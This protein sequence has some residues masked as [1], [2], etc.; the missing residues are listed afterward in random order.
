ML[1]LIAAC[2]GLAA[3]KLAKPIKAE[4]W[5]S[6][7]HEDITKKALK[8]LEKDGKVK[9]AQF[10]KPYHEEI[11]KGC[12]E[13]DQED[14]I[15]RGPGMHFYSSRTPK[16]KE[17]KPV[18]GYYKNRL[19]KFAKSARTLLEENYTSALCLYKSGKTKEA[20][21]YLARAA[22]FIED[23]SCTVHVCNV[24]WVERASNLHHAYENSIN[25]TCSRFTAGEFDKRLLKTYEGDSFE[26]AANKLSVTAA[27]FL[28]KISE[29]DPLAF[30]FA[31][32]NTLKMAQQNVMTLFLKF[33]DEA[34]GE[35]KNYIT[36]GKK[37]TLKNE[38]SG[39][40]LT[41]SEGNILPDKPDKTKTQKFT[42]F[43]DSKGTIAFG[44]EDGGFINAKC[45]GLDTPKDADGAARFRLAALGNRRFRIMCGGDNFPLTLGIARSG[46][47][48]ISE[49]DPADK[50]QV[51]VI[52]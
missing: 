51:W 35:K 12:T 15:D 29:F 28:E 10:Y 4:A 23:L 25:I 27:R 24:E 49:F 21:H 38:A 39:L 45:K 6:V 36:D 46:K 34:N 7:T 44:T 3:Y 18:N 8:L 14:D 42:A 11:L 40:V 47:L 43:I 13:P 2:A 50:G 31:G 22:H 5:F 16:G 41:V 33:Y 48:A 1:T 26:N 20:M 52:G 30:S 19:G 17:L 32:D 37:Y 9:Q